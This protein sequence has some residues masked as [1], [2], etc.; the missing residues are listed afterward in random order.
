MVNIKQF[1]ILVSTGLMTTLQGCAQ[2]RLSMPQPEMVHGLMQEHHVP[3]I[4]IGIIDSDHSSR[5]KVFGQMDDRTPAL[6]NTVF[7]IASLTKPL[8]FM[9]TL[10]LISDGSWKLDEPL[11]HYWTDPD[12]SSDPRNLKLTTRHVLSHQSGLPNWRGHEPGGK[13]S[14]AFEPGTQWKYSGEGFE[15]LRQ[16][17]EHKFGIP[18]EQLVDSVLLQPWKMV[19][20]RFYW[21]D[22]M[23]ASR[24]ANRHRDDGSPY[25]METW[26]IANASNLV[27]TTVGDYCKFGEHVLAGADLD[28]KVAAE[29]ISAQTTFENRNEFGLG[30]LLVKN[31]T[32]GEYALVHTGS[33]PGINTLIILFPKSKRGIVVFTNGDQGDKVYRAIAEQAGPL[34]KEVMSRVS[35]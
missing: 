12:V 4:G 1:F 7:N 24:Y 5:V 10:K 11:H 27:L 35:G 9:T 21:D 19:D 32:G 23:D 30:W 22:T 34:A 14:F 13:L 28:P 20:T 16:A 26:K 17:M 6:E 29:M 8:V 25:E 18:I 3:I 2:D 33:N 15:Y 31:L